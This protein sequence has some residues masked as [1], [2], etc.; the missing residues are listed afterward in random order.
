MVTSEM[1]RMHTMPED[2][3]SDETTLEIE[4][5]IQNHPFVAKLRKE[6]DLVESRPHLDIPVLFRANVLTAG[7]L[8]GPD[9]IVVPPIVFSDKE[10][11]RLFAIQYV[12]DQLC[13]HPGIV[14]GGLLATLMD[15]TLAR[16]CFPALPKKV[17]MTANLDVNYRAPCRAGTYIVIK[18]QTT[19]VEGRK[20]WVSGTLEEL[21]AP[22]VEGDGKV[23]VEASALMI[24]PRHVGPL[25]REVIPNEQIPPVAPISSAWRVSP[26][27]SPIHIGPCC[28]EAF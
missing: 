6:P 23:L 7:I 11:K 9:R 14:H 22:D 15:E 16:C 28:S 13:G 21:P 17:G 18:A 4:H 24:E 3:V 26:F 8:S 27:I 20:A 25:M 5:Y 12:G 1:V 10:G 19:K 2:G